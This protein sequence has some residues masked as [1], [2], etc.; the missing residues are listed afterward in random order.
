M[1]H[2]RK[3]IIHPTQRI[4]IVSSKVFHC[5]IR[6]KRL[7]QNRVFLLRRGPL[8]GPILQHPD[9]IDYVRYLFLQANFEDSMRIIESKFYMVSPPQS[10]D[11]LNDS[12]SFELDQYEVH[13]LR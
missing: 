2:K 7:I 11:S 9:D 3:A 5:F 10:S 13:S 1:R 6:Y 8:L 4:E 12:T